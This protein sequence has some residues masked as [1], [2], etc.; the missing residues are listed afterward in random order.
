MNFYI[1]LKASLISLI[2]SLWFSI[3]IEILTN[4]S[5]IPIASFVSEETPA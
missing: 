3:P 1:L 5:F 4:L 2:K